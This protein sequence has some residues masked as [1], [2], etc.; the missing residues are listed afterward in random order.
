MAEPV[1]KLITRPIQSARSARSGGVPDANL[2]M[3]L[4]RG[5]NHVLAYRRKEVY[6][7]FYTIKSSVGGLGSTV[8]QAQFACHTGYGATQ[9]VWHYVLQ[10]SHATT[11]VDPTVTFRAVRSGPVTVEETVHFGLNNAGTGMRYAPSAWSWGVVELDVLPNTTYECEV[12]SYDGGTCL[13]L[14]VFE[15]A[16]V[17]ADSTVDYYM[18][19]IVAAGQ[20][21]D[22]N[23]RTKLRTGLA[24][25][26]KRNGSHLLNVGR[27]GN[28]VVPSGVLSVTSTTYTNPYDS[29][30]TVSNST[31]GWYNDGTLWTGQ[32]RLSESGLMPYATL[33]AYAYTST[34]TGAVRFESDAGT[35]IELTGLTS[36]PGWSYTNAQLGGGALG[37]GDFSRMDFQAKADTGGASIYIIGVS[38]YMYDT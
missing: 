5:T 21:I 26:W 13:A 19:P 33:A 9:L 1:S 17:Y 20:G 24:N 6:N 34:G 14:S 22:D 30:T 35:I 23:T 18:D 12:E 27:M 37:I 28:G 25:I 38:L 3:A 2:A 31:V 4:A 8:T 16:A 36:T 7:N 11:G 15:K 32:T 10:P 29:S